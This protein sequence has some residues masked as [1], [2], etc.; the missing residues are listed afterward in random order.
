MEENS[1]NIE[2][3]IYNELKHSIIT[4]QYKPNSQLVETTIAKKMGVS[5]TP[6]R[7]ALQ[8]L[9]YEGLVNIIPRKGAFVAQTSIEEFVNLFSSRLLLEKE[10]ARIAAEQIS[11]SDLDYFNK[12]IIEERTTHE[13]KNLEKFLDINDKMHMLIANASKNVYYTKFIQEL[14]M[15]SN[16]YLIFH[17]D[18]FTKPI[19]ELH[20][21]N[22]HM[23]IYEALKSRNPKKSAKAMEQHIKSIFNNLGLSTKKL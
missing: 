18:F 7:S 4:R 6:I 9:S 13:E 3:K 2:T 1:N 11:N 22:E 8:K 10:A 19:K 5:R 14:T 20:S 21:L 17:D 12:L 16:I 15:K 23:L